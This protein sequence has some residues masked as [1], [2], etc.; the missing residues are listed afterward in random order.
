[1]NLAHIKVRKST[2]VE[3]LVDH[4][5]LDHLLRQTTCHLHLVDDRA[6]RARVG[7]NQ[8]RVVIS[9][10][11]LVNV[12]YQVFGKLATQ[13]RQRARNVA[14]LLELALPRRNAGLRLSLVDELPHAVVP[15]H[16][17]DLV[18]RLEAE[19]GN[20]LQHVA[21]LEIAYVRLLPHVL[22]ADTE[23]GRLH[24]PERGSL[25]REHQIKHLL[26]QRV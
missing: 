23:A 10:F 24:E 12:A 14:L 2:R 20:R 6:L 15:P 26:L 8:G 17:L 3:V 11:V 13:V 21:G 19:V 18:K 25:Q 22:Y 7:H 16:L 5:V 9:V 1:M 4:V